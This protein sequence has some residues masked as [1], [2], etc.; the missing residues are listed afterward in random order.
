MITDLNQHG[1]A[2]RCLLRLRENE[3]HPGMSDAAFIARFL[4]RFPEW[5]AQPGVTNSAT[6]LELA[7]DFGLADH[8]TSVRDYDEMV[9]EHRAGRGI[10]VATERAP[11][12]REPAAGGQYMMLLVAADEAAFTVW[13]P[14]PS[15]QSDVLPRASR[16]WW[17]RW[18]ATAIVLV[19]GAAA[20][21][22]H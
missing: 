4:P 1:A 10:L 18:Q 16:G 11:E 22:P 3:G 13:C 2:C 19:P 21:G 12:Q 5:H 8:L 17:D 7:R 9:R 20:V 14:Y 6:L 15:G